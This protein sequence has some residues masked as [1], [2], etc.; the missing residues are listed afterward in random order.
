MILQRPLLFARNPV[1]LLTMFFSLLCTLTTLNCLSAAQDNADLAKIAMNATVRVE[2][3]DTNGNTVGR[4]SG[5]VVK[6][7]RVATSF[8]SIDGA[9]S[10]K[11]IFADGKELKTDQ[12]AGVNRY[13][14]WALIPIDDKSRASLPVLPKKNSAGDHCYWLEVKPD[15]T[16]V[17][18]DGQ[19]S[20]A[21]SNHPWGERLAL[22]GTYSY[23]ALGGPV[24][25]GKGQVIGILGGALPEAYVRQGDPA[26]ATADPPSGM[27]PQ[28]HDA[29]DVYE[30]ANGTAI[31]SSL[32]PQTLFAAP[33]ALKILWDNGDMTPPVTNSKYVQSGLI[34]TKDNAKKKAAERIGSVEFKKS[35]ETAV[36]VIAF[37]KS[38]AFKTTAQV[39]IFDFENHPIAA[40][41]I[42]KFS[43]KKG[44]A[45]EKNWDI[46]VSQLQ[47]GIYR[48]DILI[49]DGVAWREY[50]KVAE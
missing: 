23:A 3:L 41:E 2:K 35:V 11:L 24:L 18:A 45:A 27:S 8:R 16:R 5:F 49:G 20:A 15:G 42:E 38:E 6:D 26:P 19:I 50:F 46:P 39:K 14:D 40:G 21:T 9:T 36:V 43:L 12:V 48:V 25:D 28:P 47:P 32:L 30:G 29:N 37:D 1:R 44:T 33:R 31:P 17:L 34:T 4:S 10:L 13:Q 7:G 22:S